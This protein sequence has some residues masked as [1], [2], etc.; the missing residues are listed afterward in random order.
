M[1]IVYLGAPITVN[2]S[3][4]QTIAV[5]TNGTVTVEC[6]SGLGLTDGATIGSIH[7]SATYGP[8]SAVGVARITATVRDG[9]YEVS[10]GQPIPID[11]ALAASGQ[12]VLDDASRATLKNSGIGISETQYVSMNANKM[13]RTRR[14]IGRVVGGTGRW[15]IGLVGDSTTAGAGAGTSGTT[16]IVGAALKSYPQRLSARLATLLGS[17]GQMAAIEGGVAAAGSCTLPQYN[18]NVTFGGG[19]VAGGGTY[20]CPTGQMIVLPSAGT[21]AYAPGY[22]FDTLEFGYVQNAGLGTITPTIGSGTSTPSSLSTVG[23][24]SAQ[25]GKFTFSALNTSVTL[26]GSIA[27]SY[28]G[29]ALAYDSTKPGVDVIPCCKWGGFIADFGVTTNPWSTGSAGMWNT[30]SLDTIVIQLTINDSNA[31]TSLASYISGMQ[32]LITLL[33]GLTNAPDVIL[34]SGWPSGTANATN[35][36]L[37]TFQQAC[38]SLATSNNIPYVA[39]GEGR[40]VS[41][42]NFSDWYSGDMVHILPQG[43]GAEGDYLARALLQMSS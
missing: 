31:G 28:I 26:T 34:M 32:T 5:N 36:T 4:G 15:R 35:G 27:S 25:N 18:S 6:V 9:A 19:T 42:A 23:A 1:N 24:Y 30:M 21:Y 16:N 39:Y 41:Y 33:K 43:Y 22:S 13:P 8:F 14:A 38:A 29:W 2:L 11:T 37:A 20:A 40:V 3:V 17:T 12:T 7:G 10:D